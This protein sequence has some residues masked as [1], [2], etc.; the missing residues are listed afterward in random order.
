MQI[1]VLSLKSKV[2]K[3]CMGSFGLGFDLGHSI[4]PKM[5]GWAKSKSV[6]I[7]DLQTA[8]IASKLKMAGHN[9]TVAN[10]P[11]IADAYYIHSSLNGFEHELNVSKELKDVTFFGATAKYNL[12]RIKK[13]IEVDNNVFPMWEL[14]DYKAFKYFPSLKKSPVVPMVTAYGCKYKCSYC[15]YCSYYGE[16][17]PRPLNDVIAEIE[18]N[19]KKYDVKGII[20]RD[21]LFTADNDRTIKI[22]NELKKYNL[23]FACETRIETVTL[24]LLYEM[25]KSGCKAIHFGIEC[26][27]EEVLKSVNRTKPSN[28]TIKA[29]IDY[30]EIIGIKT[31]CFFILGFPKDT[32][33]TIKETINLSIY[34]NPN[35][36]EFFV[37]TP[38]P[39]TKLSSQVELTE[40]YENMT[41][42]NLC[43]KHNNFTADR[44]NELKEQAYNKFYLRPKWMSKFL[45]ML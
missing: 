8:L 40:K 30:C 29:I 11:G 34:L 21:P 45:K 1:Q 37:S 3:D 24:E 38:Y 33:E 44:I 9:V 6:N 36:A 14:F 15:P 5:I 18:N 19:V 4:I 16:W 13:Y 32:E 22:I 17:N 28:N 7:P 41:G 2:N 20:F 12:E 10:E 23:E 25:K 39:G 42:Y 35:I 43:F 27:N 26:G 31:T